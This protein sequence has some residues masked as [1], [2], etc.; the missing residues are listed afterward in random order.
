MKFNAAPVRPVCQK[1]EPKSASDRTSMVDALKWLALEDAEFAFDIDPES[2]EIILSGTSELQLDLKVQR[3]ILVFGIDVLV[4]A[5]KVTY[6]ETLAKATSIDYTHKKLTGSARQFAR[7]ILDLEPCGRDHGNVFEST[8][9]EGAIPDEIIKAV[10][11]GVRSVWENGVLIGFPIVDMK[12]VLYD[13]AYHEADSSPVAFEIAAR[14]AMK[15]GCEKGGMHILEP[16]MKVK[17]E[18]PAAFVGKVLSNLNGRRGTIGDQAMHGEN[19]VI[20]GSIPLANMFGYV[21]ELQQLTAGAGTYTMAY[22]HYAL[23]PRNI[24]RGPDDFP[25]AVGMRA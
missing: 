12:V 15:E 7:V 9:A 5:P 1:I 25:P 6:R 11:K 13:A 2:G 4:G 16:V 22:S 19:C 3:L 20:R 10:E 17:V 21:N 18:T 23:V 8:I 24:G 14:A